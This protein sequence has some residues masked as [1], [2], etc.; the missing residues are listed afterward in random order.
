MITSSSAEVPLKSAPIQPEWI[1]EGQPKARN[2]ILSQS[3]DRSAVT[4][5]WDCTA[6]RFNWYY[7]VD[8][9]V[10]ITKGE[11]VVS[12]DGKEFARLQ[13]GDVAFFPAGTHAVWHVET[14]VRKVAFCRKPL[15]TVVG[16]PMR[17][18]WKVRGMM[19]SPSM[20]M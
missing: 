18:F 10:H 11:V 5:V 8:E 14:Y 15:P 9:T 20:A 4:L 13:R 7:D 3:S 16:I 17:I 12:T 2:A 19:R 6:G 1:I